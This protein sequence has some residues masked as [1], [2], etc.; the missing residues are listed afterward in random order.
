MLAQVFAHLLIYIF[1]SPFV[2]LFLRNVQLRFSS[3][4][5]NPREGLARNLYCYQKILYKKIHTTIVILG[6]NS[7]ISGTSTIFR[8]E[9][10]FH[11]IVTTH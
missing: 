10:I 3:L 9:F 1:P 5:K 7:R 4:D 11:V 2:Y 8:V 6:V